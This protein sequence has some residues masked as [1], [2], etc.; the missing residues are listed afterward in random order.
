LKAIANALIRTSNA[1]DII[2]LS[3]VAGIDQKYKCGGGTFGHNASIAMWWTPSAYHQQPPAVGTMSMDDISII[4]IA[5]WDMGAYYQGVNLWFTSMRSMIRQ[6]AVERNGRPL[7]IMNLH[8]VYKSKCQLKHDSEEGRKKLQLCLTSKCDDLIFGFRDALAAA[9]K[10][11]Q[12]EGH[13]N[14]HLVDT[15]GVTDSSFAEEQS[16]GVHFGDDIVDM[17]LQVVLLAICGGLRQANGVVDSVV[18][19]ATQLEVK[20]EQG[21]KITY[22]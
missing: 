8:R 4:S 22:E 19:P 2:K 15:Y 18:C 13:T 9:V 21:R 14:V 3:T 20:F 12:I 5:A 10:C 6:A 7:Y 17:E 16:N 1:T 11:S